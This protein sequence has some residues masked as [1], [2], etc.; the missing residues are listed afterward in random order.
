MIC[1]CIVSW[2]KYCDSYQYRKRCIISALPITSILVVVNRNATYSLF[3]SC[4][5]MCL[6]LSHVWKKTQRFPRFKMSLILT[7]I[8]IVYRNETS[9]LSYICLCQVITRT[10]SF[11]NKLIKLGSLNLSDQL[12]DTLALKKTGVYCYT[13]VLLVFV[14]VSACDKFLSNF[15]QQ[16]MYTFLS[17]G[18]LIHVVLKKLLPFVT[19]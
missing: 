17:F 2:H 7:L 12:S 18:R 3:Y 5:V 1:T 9:Y 15:S 10:S 19:L 6:D 14:R 8:I 13:T 11:S 16:Q 4:R